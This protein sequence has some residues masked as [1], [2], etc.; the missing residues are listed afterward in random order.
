MGLVPGTNHRFSPSLAGRT[1]PSRYRAR[2]EA[3][4]TRPVFSGTI[5]TRRHRR[6]DSSRI[7]MPETAP[8]GRPVGASAALRI[9]TVHGAGIT[10]FISGP[11]GHPRR[12]S[13]IGTGRSLAMEYAMDCRFRDGCERRANGQHPPAGSAA[14]RCVPAAACVCCTWTWPRCCTIEA[15]PA[16]NTCLVPRASG[17]RSDG[18]PLRSRMPRDCS[19]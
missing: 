12:V 13:W 14:D 3:R 16:S 11:G 15:M 19:R 8:N 7:V 4:R 6:R 10:R 9:L 5:P 18:W 2:R 1:A 17:Q